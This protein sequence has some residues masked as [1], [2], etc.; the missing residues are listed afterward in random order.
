MVLKQVRK[1]TSL[2]VGK[3]VTLLDLH[4]IDSNPGNA[5]DKTPKSTWQL[6]WKW[7]HDTIGSP[8]SNP[9]GK[10]RARGALLPAVLPAC[11]EQSGAVAQQVIG[12]PVG[13]C[14]SWVALTRRFLAHR[15]PCVG[16]LSVPHFAC[17]QVFIRP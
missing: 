11:D 5:L 13:K 15:V 9:P 14:Q 17:M 4:N 16:F 3:R 6:D 10:S 12:T 8:F 2:P 1:A 7:T